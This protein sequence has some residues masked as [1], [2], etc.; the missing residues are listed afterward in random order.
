MKNQYFGDIRDLFKYDL[1]LEIATATE[2]VGR[3]FYIPMLTADGP[4]RD[5]SRIDY[6][7]AKAGYRNTELRDYLSACVEEGGR[8]IQKIKDFFLTRGIEVDIYEEDHYFTHE[9]R[10]EYFRKIDQ[11]SLRGA[12]ILVDPDNGLEVKDPGEKH[13]LYSEVK[14]LF[15]R[16]E[17]NSILMIYQ[18]LPRQHRPTYIYGRTMELKHLTGQ[19]PLYL[20]DNEIIFFLLAKDAKLLRDLYGIIEIYQKKYPQ[21]STEKLA[22]EELPVGGE[23]E[24]T[25]N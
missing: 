13:L 3:L 1:A 24:V 20:S 15:R 12:L 17:K 21:L 22:Y 11:A 16:M 19:K 10:G 9:R 6:E 5:G 2:G 23:G 4:R 7:R 14:G 8:N 25:P 18:H